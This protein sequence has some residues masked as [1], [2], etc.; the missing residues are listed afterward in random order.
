MTRT[1]RFASVAMMLLCAL[2]AS[3]ATFKITGVYNGDEYSGSKSGDVVEQ[4]NASFKILFPVKAQSLSNS[5]TLSGSNGSYT[6]QS[7]YPN[8][9][10]FSD[11]GSMVFSFWGG[12]LTADGTY[13]LTIPQGTYVAE[14]GDV[15]EEYVGTW[16]IK[17]PETFDVTSITN[18][19]FNK[20]TTLKWLDMYFN[21]N[22]E[23]GIT[24]CN[25]TKIEVYKGSLPQN[26]ISGGNINPDGSC[27][28][29]YMD[30]YTGIE[31]GKTVGSQKNSGTYRLVF[32]KGAFRDSKNR[33]SNAFEATWTVSPS[34][35]EPTSI[36]IISTDGTETGVAYDIVGRQVNGGTKGIRI[37][38]GKKQLT[39]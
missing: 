23:G 25:G 14:N 36:T 16:T 32:E 4:I 21:V 20:G 9:Y 5:V 17:A 37:V 28:I 33:V 24:S 8:S 11:E 7:V 13:T 18:R 19:G 31:D 2:S 3:A 35:E 15:N 27:D 26:K 34:A 39:Y 10:Y 29:Y 30:W 6:P 1:L 38:N 22:C 12:V